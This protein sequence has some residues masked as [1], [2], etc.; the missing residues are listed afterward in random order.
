MQKFTVLVMMLF[1]VSCASTKSDFKIKDLKNDYGFIVGSVSINYNG[2]NLTK[3]C[4]IQFNEREGDFYYFKYGKDLYHQL[5]VGKNKI[6]GFSCFNGPLKFAQYIFP[7]AL[8][9]E[10]KTKKQISYIGDIKIDWKTNNNTKIS[11]LFGALGYLFFKDDVDGKLNLVVE[12]NHKE[13]LKKF[14]KSMAVK[15]HKY[16]LSL[17]SPANYETNE[18]K[19]NCLE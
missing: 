16:T 5:P 19:D 13:T 6:W 1:I 7:Q 10:V 3:N 9:F 11:M 2:V 8:E 4:N 14:N 18:C 17:I 12:D 15:N